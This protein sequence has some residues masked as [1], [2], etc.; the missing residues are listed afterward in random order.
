MR[1]LRLLILL[2]TLA[3]PLALHAQREKLTPDDLDFV[4]KTWPQA[5]QTNTG[6]RYIIEKEGAGDPPSPG[7]M[8][9]VLY[10]GH[11]LD[12]KIFDHNEDRAH[13]FVFRVG[14]QMVIEGW[15]EVLQEMKPGERRLIIVPS[16]LAYGTRGRIP[17]IPRDATL[18]FDLELLKV[19]RLQ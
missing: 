11:F 12:G 13:P 19:D 16:E 18:V 14:R 6:I 7:D 1:A 15:D 10:V 9:S 4:N 5:L 2:G 8:V 17:G 3:L